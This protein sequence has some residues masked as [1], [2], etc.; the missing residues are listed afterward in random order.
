MEAQKTIIPITPDEEL[1][2]QKEF[3][4]LIIPTRA[5]AT[6]WSSSLVYS[7][8]PRKPTLTTADA[9]AIHISAT[10]WLWLA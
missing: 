6:R 7:S 4:G 8:L 9:M 3:E 10:H 5:K 2:I 1:M